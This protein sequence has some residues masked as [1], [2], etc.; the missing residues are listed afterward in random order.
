M[1]KFIFTLALLIGAC[2]FFSSDTWDISVQML[3]YEITFPFALVLLATFT[4]CFFWNMLKKPFVWFQK[5]R[6]WRQNKK[7]QNKDTFITDVLNALSNENKTLYPHLLSEA[8]K[9]Y[10]SNSQIY[11][12]LQSLFTPNTD[13]LIQ[14]TKDSKTLLA[15]TRGLIQQALNDGEFDR[16]NQLLSSIPEKQQNVLWVQ[17]TKWNMALMQNDWAGALKLL[18]AQKKMYDTKTYKTYRSYLLMKLGQIKQ[19]YAL[20]PQHPAI[21]LA[22][23]KVFPNKAEKVIINA[24]NNY[25]TWDLYQAYVHTLQQLPNN[26]KMKSVLRLIKKNPYA[27][28]ALLACADMSIQTEQW[29]RAKENLEVYLQS[30]PL[31][32]QVATMMALIERRGFHHEQMAQQWETKPVE[33]ENDS[34]CVCKKCNHTIPQWQVSCPYCNAFAE[35]I[36][37]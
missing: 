28:L 31:T 34:I 30:H 5:F 8:K 15:G 16:V 20:N 26:K 1:L 9:L 22:Y 29:Q 24:W 3:G 17:Q 33:A 7:Q 37:K 12:L 36:F 6:S 2:I 21:A 13:T 32:K 19:S 14:M 25:P 27:K 10:G 4:V 35:V 23:A 11:L 18:D